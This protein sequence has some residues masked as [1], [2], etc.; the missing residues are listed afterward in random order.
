MGV[1]DDGGPV[2]G[3]G[4]MPQSTSAP[5]VRFTDGQRTVFDRAQ[6]AIRA[7]AEHR[8]AAEV[9]AEEARRRERFK[10]AL[11]TGLKEQARQHPGFQC[12]TTSDRDMFLVS[13]I[14]TVSELVESVVKAMSDG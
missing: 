12:E 5:E 7:D 4:S 2:S 13:G 11:I 14:L 10:A 1:F 9:K 8:Y 3:Q 6:E